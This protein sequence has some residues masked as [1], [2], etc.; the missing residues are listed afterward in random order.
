MHAC[1]WAPRGWWCPP[2]RVTRQRP[3]LHLSKAEAM[4]QPLE[5]LAASAPA[6]FR[7]MAQ[8]VDKGWLATEPPQLMAGTLL[9]GEATETSMVS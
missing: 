5:P 1:P 4:P 2:T 3:G 8:V 9:R 6:S 7:N